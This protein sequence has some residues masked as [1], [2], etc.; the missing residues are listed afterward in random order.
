MRAAERTMRLVNRRV[1]SLM[2]GVLSLALLSVG[3]LGQEALLR[4][5]TGTACTLE[6]L[7]ARAPR[8]T[9]ILRTE[10][11]PSTGAVPAFCQVDAQ[12]ATLG[13]SVTIRLRL[14]ES[15]NG[16]FLFHGVGGLAGSFE[17]QPPSATNLN[18]MLPGLLRGYAVASTDTGHQAASSD[19]SWALNHLPK[20]LDY[21]HRGTHAATVADK[22][23]TSG[24]YGAAPTRSYFTGC[25]NGGRMALQEAQRYPQ[26]FDGIIAGAPAIGST[27]I[28]RTLGYQALLASVNS[29]IPAAK[30]NAVSRAVTAT[31]DGLD[32]LVDGLVS[33]PKA[34]TFRPETLTCRAGDASDCLTTGQVDTLKKLYAGFR[35]SNGS[36]ETLGFPMGHEAGATGWTA[37]IVG[38]AAPERQNDGSLLFSQ[39]PPAGYRFQ[40]Q[41]LR[42]L[43]FERDQPNYDWRRFNF[44]RDAPKLQFMSEIMRPTADLRPFQARGGRLLLYHGW[45]DP[46]ISAYSTIDYY[47]RVTRTLGGGSTAEDTVR[48][49]LAPGMHHCAGGPG[50]NSFAAEAIAALEAW[51]ERGVAPNSILA[52]HSDGSGAIDRTRPLCRWPLIAK[53]QG[54]GSIDEAANFS[55]SAP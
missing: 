4:S 46:A 20:K 31:C 12:V 2:A 28:N 41:Y 40:D 49:F 24:Y 15:W 36:A 27:S 37:W 25:S 52:T 22:A 16:K 47:E 38:Q 42:Y 53:Y 3:V 11:L 21:A 18:T 14:P 10:R 44:D 45:A 17:P 5:G 6:A 54:T 51:V 19:G 39:A 32:G 9:T 35:T 29:Y 23:L 55:C 50:P 7:G 1:R 13:N 43:A 26:D 48:L 33:N 34:C 8:G 30:L